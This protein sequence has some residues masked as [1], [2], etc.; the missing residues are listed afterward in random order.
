[1]YTCVRRPNVKRYPLVIAICIYIT[2][3]HKHL[4]V[5]TCRS[6]DVYIIDCVNAVTWKRRIRNTQFLKAMRHIIIYKVLKLISKLSCY[7]YH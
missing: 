2:E 7:L 6:N 3:Y 4:A 5:N 1:M